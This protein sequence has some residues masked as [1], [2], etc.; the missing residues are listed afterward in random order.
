MH[1]PAAGSD[2]DRRHG[3]GSPQS[4]FKQSQI[5]FWRCGR[6]SEIRSMCCTNMLLNHSR[7][8]PVG[9][10]ARVRLLP[11]QETAREVP[12]RRE[13]R[14]ILRSDSSSSASLSV[15]EGQML[16][17][18]TTQTWA[19]SISMVE[20]GGGTHMRGWALHN[21]DASVTLLHSTVHVCVSTDVC[22]I[23]LH[24][25]PCMYKYALPSVCVCACVFVDVHICVCM[26]ACVCVFLWGLQLWQDLHHNTNIRKIA[27]HNHWITQDQIQWLSRGLGSTNK[28]HTRTHTTGNAFNLHLGGGGSSDFPNFPPL[29]H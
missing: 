12:E 6:R 10:R 20:L 11:L 1:A 17:G 22:P 14:K 21:Y 29:I 25:H 19:R 13:Q 26:C 9:C 16:W 8:A 4:V 18:G 27:E 15:N 28:T 7:Y 24:T 2:A 3:R 5:R 23:A